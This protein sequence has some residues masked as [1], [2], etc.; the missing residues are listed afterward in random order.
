MPKREDYQ[1]RSMKESD[2]EMILNW[3]DHNL[4]IYLHQ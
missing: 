1:L 3:Y 4:L 2:L